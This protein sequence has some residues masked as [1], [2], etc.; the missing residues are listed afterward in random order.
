MAGRD[1]TQQSA[2]EEQ[3]FGLEVLE[4]HRKASVR[5]AYDLGGK[6]YRAMLHSLGEVADEDA[7]IGPRSDTARGGLDQ[8]A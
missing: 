5:C 7:Q 1:L 6:L 3:G 2:E 4:A 8:C